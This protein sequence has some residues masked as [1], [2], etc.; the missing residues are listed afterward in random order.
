MSS[1]TYRLSMNVLL[2]QRDVAEEEAP[3]GDN[4]RKW[5]RWWACLT[6]CQQ[7][8]N[9]PA[10]ATRCTYGST[11]P[12]STYKRLFV[13]RSRRAKLCRCPDA[14][15]PRRNAQVVAPAGDPSWSPKLTQHAE[16]MQRSY[17]KRPGATLGPRDARRQ[18][19]HFVEGLVR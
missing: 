11:G 7:W 1:H 17:V 19:Q 6:P 9:W 2:A 12:R 15:W 3:A 14:R 18:Q 8:V 4:Q 16:K 10:T 5:C 13:T